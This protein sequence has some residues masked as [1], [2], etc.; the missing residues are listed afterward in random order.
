MEMPNECLD[1]EEHLREKSGVIL[2][3]RNLMGASNANSL[4]ATQN[5]KGEETDEFI[6]LCILLNTIDLK[7]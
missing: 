7:P 3:N 1:V 4:V 6:L 2:S 5:R